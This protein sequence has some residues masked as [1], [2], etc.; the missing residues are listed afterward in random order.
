MSSTNSTR[1]GS[2]SFLYN[3]KL[4]EGATFEEGCDLPEEAAEFMSAFLDEGASENLDGYFK[5]VNDELHENPESPTSTL[6][7]EKPKK[8]RT[9]AKPYKL[10]SSLESAPDKELST[11][12]NPFQTPKIP[13]HVFEKGEDGKVECL[14]NSCNKRVDSQHFK[15]HAILHANK[16]GF[17]RSLNPETGELER[18]PCELPQ[19][20]KTY[21]TTES[22]KTHLL[23]F[24]NLRQFPEEQEVYR[25][26]LCRHTVSTRYT[27]Q[28]GFVNHLITKHREDSSIKV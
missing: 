26:S 6:V 12:N 24:H 13:T 16:A 11:L 22:Y 8:H 18:I 7:R 19:C 10:R 21:L 25:C 23:N 5:S 20:T 4:P 27:H 15:A 9:R 2:Y 28:R 3:M 17:N 14:M 1:R